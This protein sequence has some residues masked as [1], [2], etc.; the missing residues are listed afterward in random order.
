MRGSVAVKLA[1][2]RNFTHQARRAHLTV[3]GDDFTV[4]ESAKQVAWLGEAVKRDM[5]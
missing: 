3:H 2:Q 1:W 4:V 5:N